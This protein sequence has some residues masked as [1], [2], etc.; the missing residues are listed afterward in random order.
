MSDRVQTVLFVAYSAF[1]A[2]AVLVAA[3]LPTR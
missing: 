1:V 2:Y 3:V